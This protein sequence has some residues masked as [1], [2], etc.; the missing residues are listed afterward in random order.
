MKKQDRRNELF[1]L[2]TADNAKEVK[3]ALE[4]NRLT[5]KW[6]MHRLDRDFGI[7]VGKQQLSDVLE[8][9]KPIGSKTQR[10]IW[11]CERVI[12]EYEKYYGGR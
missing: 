7:V 2:I 3:Y 8:G 6:L 1:E 4:R 9:R 5:Q 12:E 10:L 11:C